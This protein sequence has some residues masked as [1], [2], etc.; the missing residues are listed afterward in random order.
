MM[1]QEKEHPLVLLKTPEAKISMTRFDGR[2]STLRV[3]LWLVHLV[4]VHEPPRLIIS[5]SH[6]HAVFEITT[7]LHTRTRTQNPFRTYQ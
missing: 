6:S 4:A 3:M 1:I 2:E 7:T 5:P